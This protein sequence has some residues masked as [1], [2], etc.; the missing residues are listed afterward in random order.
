MRLGNIYPAK[1][2]M[3]HS[4]EFKFS[5]RHNDT[6]SGE[7][8]IAT[9]CVGESTV[10]LRREFDTSTWAFKWDEDAS[11]DH[12]WDQQVAQYRGQTTHSLRGDG[13]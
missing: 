5:P 7:P 13:I 1:D 9:K 8:I 6:D 4:T 11:F 3:I 2:G 12:P 10:P